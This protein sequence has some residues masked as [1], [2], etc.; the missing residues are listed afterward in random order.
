MQVRGN[1]SRRAQRCEG[2][3]EVA[4]LTGEYPDKVLRCDPCNGRFTCRCC[5]VP[6]GEYKGR[7]L[8]YEGDREEYVCPYCREGC[9]YDAPGGGCR[10]YPAGEKPFYLP[11]PKPLL[12]A[13]PQCVGSDRAY[14]GIDGALAAGSVLTCELCGEGVIVQFTM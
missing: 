10:F 13:C 3:G 4:D 14:L 8:E 11:G 12:R 9:S 5:G 6:H 2:C 7:A 1:I